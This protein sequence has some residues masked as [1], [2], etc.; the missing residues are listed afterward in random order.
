MLWEHVWLPPESGGHSLPRSLVCTVVRC[1]FVLALSGAAAAWASTST[2][3]S[4]VVTF[5]TPG[6]KQVSLKVCNYGLCETIVKTV[7][8][9]DP[10]PAVTS[11]SA[12]PNPALTGDVIP[13]ACIA[14]GQPPLTF[15]WRILNVLGTQIATLSGPSANWT[16][17][18]PPG[19]YTVY[20]DLSNAH[21]SLTPQPPTAVTVLPSASYIFS[22]GFEQG[23]PNAWLS[24]PP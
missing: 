4:P 14:T 21:G 7:T 2:A 19:V 8:V 16:A 15:G 5:G 3:P 10:T 23:S 13:L 17:N 20:L 12:T 1:S 24:S 9:L 18:V 11:V 22:D 6:T